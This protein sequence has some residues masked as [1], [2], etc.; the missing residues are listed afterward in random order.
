M[1]SHSAY[2]LNID[3]S[4]IPVPIRHIVNVC[5]SPERFGLSR[6]FVVS[7]FER[8]REPVGH[9]GLARQEIMRHLIRNHGWIR[10]RYTPRND[11]WTIELSQKDEAAGRIIDTFSG[12]FINSCSDLII[13]ELSRSD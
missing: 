6:E 7:V 5:E 3:G 12:Q 2:W 1:H 11:R 4:I 8:H 13:H 10:A 9:E